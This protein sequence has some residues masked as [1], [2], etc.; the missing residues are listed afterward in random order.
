MK[1]IVYT[2]PDGGVSVVC[3]AP[4]FVAQFPTE[5]EAL[6]AVQVKAVPADAINVKI[7]DVINIPTSRRFRNCW[8]Q[9]GTTPPVVDLP[10]AREQRM[11]EIR[12]ERDKRLAISDG[13]MARAQDTGTPAEVMVLRG[14]RQ[15]LRDLPV[16]VETELAM[17]QLVDG[18][19]TYEPTWPV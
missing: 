14:K 12:T 3:P 18:L 19:A 9:V 11:S 7:C 15:A 1:R 2:R 16:T 13:Q 6:A 5:Q 10:L 17:I 4:E 8:R